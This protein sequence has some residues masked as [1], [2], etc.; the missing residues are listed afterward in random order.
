MRKALLLLFVNGLLMAQNPELFTSDWYISKIVTNGQTTTTPK[1]DFPLYL[2]KFRTFAIGPDTGYY[3]NS[4]HVNSCR[5]EIAFIP[6]TNSL[7]KIGSSCTL[8]GYIGNNQAAVD[9]YDSKHCNFFIYPTI[10]TIFNYDI[11]GNGSGKTLILTNSLN[12]NQIHYN[13]F[14]LSTKDVKAVNKTFLIYP[15]P[16]KD[17]LYIRNVEKNLP[18]KIFDM[19]GKLVYEMISNE[20]NLKINFSNFPK[21]QYI[22]NIEN[23]KSSSFTK[24]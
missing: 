18:V 21:G 19:Q 24:E 15:N 1:M 20:K 6:N 4:S 7:T 22:L 9:D 14:Y 5:F 3:L 16:V 23:Y 10:S 8:M 17:D 11:V 2:S 12:G 13:S